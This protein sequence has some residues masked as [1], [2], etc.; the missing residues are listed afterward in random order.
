MHVEGLSNS[1]LSSQDVHLHTQAG[2]HKARGIE[3]VYKD[4]PGRAPTTHSS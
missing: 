1:R 2:G 4:V 3:G